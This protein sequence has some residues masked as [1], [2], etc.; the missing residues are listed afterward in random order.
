[1]I[2]QVLLI[3]A[4]ITPMAGKE[5]AM[6]SLALYYRAV[7]TIESDMNRYAES[8]VSTA[9]SYFQVT[10]PAFRTAKRRARRMQVHITQGKVSELSYDQQW[11]LLFIDLYQRKGTNHYI[12][13]ILEGDMQVAKAAYYLFH[14]TN[15]DP[16]TVRR[17]ERIFREVYYGD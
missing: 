17:A 8:A 16:A 2:N 7:A 6:D 3:I 5:A 14:H 10:D 9:S 1:M 13:G 11:K 12:K 4:L 15:P